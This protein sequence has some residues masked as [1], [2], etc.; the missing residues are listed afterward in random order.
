MQIFYFNPSFI[1]CNGFVQENKTV[2]SSYPIQNYISN[3]F[4]ENE[5]LFLY[6][7]MWSFH[8]CLLLLHHSLF[9]VFGQIWNQID[10]KIKVPKAQERLCKRISPWHWDAEPNEWDRWR[11]CLCWRSSVHSKVRWVIKMTTLDTK[12]NILYSYHYNIYFFNRHF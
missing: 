11:Y 9:N 5:H 6:N 4:W 8:K 7:I 2:K 10:Q 12:L 3:L 1:A